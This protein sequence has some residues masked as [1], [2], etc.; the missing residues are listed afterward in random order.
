[1][2][3]GIKSQRRASVNL[4]LR[5]AA[6]HGIDPERALRQAG[7]DSRT[8]LNKGTSL[9]D[10]TTLTRVVAESIGDTP[11]L[12]LDLGARYHLTAYG[13]YGFALLASPTFGEAMGLAGRFFGLNFAYTALRGTTAGR[14]Y[15][16]LVDDSGLA[17]DMRRFL[18]ERDIAAAL[19]SVRD[20]LGATD[21]LHQVR[22]RQPEPPDPRRF[23]E[24]F[25]APTIFGADHNELVFDATIVD[26]PLPQAN[27]DTAA[28]CVEECRAELERRNASLGVAGDVRARLLRDPTRFKGM[29]A[30]AADLGMSVRSLR[31]YLA[32]EGTTFRVLLEEARLV[33]AKELLGVVGLDVQQTASRLGYAEVASFSHAFQRWTGTT[34]AEF[35]RDVSGR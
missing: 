11:G 35:R 22:L 10:E 7:L 2:K 23:T 34:P 5:F 8:A 18:C 25:S 15:R 13:I 28:A 26:R 3:T 1:M 20:L 33:M 14:D 27:P 32:E 16:M 6:D 30:V 29:G 31:R 12:G 21:E 4:V 19:V 17:P 24:F 9:A